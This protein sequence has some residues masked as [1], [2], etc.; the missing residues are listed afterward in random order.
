MLS[1]AIDIVENADINRIMPFF[2]QGAQGH[3]GIIM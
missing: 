1:A 3:E 2:P